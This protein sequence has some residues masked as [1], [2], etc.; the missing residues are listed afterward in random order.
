MGK[1][2]LA[3][4]ILLLQY[5][6]WPL[7][8]IGALPWYQLG[9]QL[10]H[11]IHKWFNWDVI[12]IWQYRRRPLV[13]TLLAERRASTCLRCCCVASAG[14]P[15]VIFLQVFH[16][17][18][19][20][21]GRPHVSRYLSCRNLFFLPSRNLTSHRPPPTRINTTSEHGSNDESSENHEDDN[22]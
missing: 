1:C 11:N 7:G 6:T 10:L 13:V 16:P 20:P 21:R 12:F 8:R 22:K 19:L 17:R 5:F 14:P 18:P 2:F 4:E 9:I 3:P 15:A